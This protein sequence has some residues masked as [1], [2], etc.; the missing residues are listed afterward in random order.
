MK[1]PF[2]GDFRRS[3]RPPPACDEGINRDAAH[4]RALGCCSLV[5]PHSSR[6]ERLPFWQNGNLAI[7][8]GRRF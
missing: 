6:I 4:S 1:Q 5:S 8:N 7:R 3:A 2:L